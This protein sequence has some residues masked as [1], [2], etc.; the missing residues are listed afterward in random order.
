MAADPDADGAADADADAGVAAGAVSAMPRLAATVVLLRES[1]NGLQTWLMTRVAK[2]AFAPGM[3]VF[4]GGAVDP[5]DQV[6][7]VGGPDPVISGIGARLGVDPATAATLLRAAVRETLEET[8]VRLDQARL[9]PW[10]H[11]LTPQREP[12]RYDTYF[13]V[14][15]MP[16]N[17]IA[18]PI[19][20]EATTADWVP[21]ADAVASCLAGQRPMLP[22]TIVTLQEVATHDSIADVLDSARTRQIRL[23]QPELRRIADGSWTAILGDGVQLSLPPTFLPGPNRSAP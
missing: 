6:A 11:W 1:P 22:P 8:G 18:A 21:V 9:H 13:F 5:V 10:A 7:E 2:M 19:S 14:A 23:I 16:P 4:P 20:T 15:A 12:R 17:E 3:T